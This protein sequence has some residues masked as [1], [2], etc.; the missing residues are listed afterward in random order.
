MF[1]I[2]FD[3]NGGSISGDDL[4]FS[5]DGYFLF[6]TVD[7][8][9]GYD[10]K[11]WSLTPD[12][13][14]L[15][16][17]DDQPVSSDITLYAIWEK[18]KCQLKFLRQD[19]SVYSVSYYI[20]GTILDSDKIIPGATVAGYDFKG[21]YLD[22]EL[23]TKF[24]PNAVI[25][26]NIV[27]YPKYQIQVYGIT[28]KESTGSVKPFVV[29]KRYGEVLDVPSEDMVAWAGHTVQ[30]YYLDKECSQAYNFSSKVTNPF[31][32][33]IKYEIDIM[34]V[35]FLDEDGSQLLESLHVDYGSIISKPNEP[36]R[37]GF[38]FLGWYLDDK[39]YEF[40][41][42]VTKSIALTAKWKEVLCKV[43]FYTRYNVEIVDPDIKGEVV[44]YGQY[45]TK[46]KD[47][48]EQGYDFKCWST[49]S[50]TV[51]EF[52][53]VNTR[54][55]SDIKLYAILQIKKVTVKY[56][57]DDRLKG[58]L[59]LD[60]GQHASPDAVIPTLN[61][62]HFVEWVDDDGNSFDFTNPIL[63]D[64][65]LHAKF[66]NTKVGFIF[67]TVGGNI[68]SPLV[69]DIN[70]PADKPDDPIKKGYTF[71]GWYDDPTFTKEYDFN[72]VVKDTT[73]I[74]ALWEINVYTVTFKCTD[75]KS[76]T[77]SVEYNETVVPITNPIRDGYIF[78][79]WTDENGNEF[80][81]DNTPI[82]QD[83]TV[84]AEWMRQSLS[85]YASSF[86]A[87]I[88]S[89]DYFIG[90]DVMSAIL[91]MRLSFTSKIE[92]RLFSTGKLGIESYVANEKDYR[93]G[94]GE[95]YGRGIT[96]E[97]YF[98]IY[99]W[100]INKTFQ[101]GYSYKF[102]F[103]FD[104]NTMSYV[105]KEV[106]YSIPLTPSQINTIIHRLYDI[107]SPQT[108]CSEIGKYLTNWATKFPIYYSL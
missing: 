107:P 102:T 86:L 9:V 85:S 21:W 105:A 25:T 77:K 72:R 99:N 41:L 88:N 17:E 52:D 39:K 97:Q 7:N 33:Y 44:R 10:F 70:T 71:L 48:Y 67:N 79:K 35:S 56:M 64:R 61:D 91:S 42:P 95:Y 53:F 54:I 28:F 49:D 31:V 73:I 3:G 106:Q 87:M 84:V 90:E 19:N 57:V 76:E 38:K 12:G 50:N 92:F 1:Y 51:K 5:D 104:T 83:T 2:T 47:Y 26:K 40:N 96:S 63:E 27:L 69:L 89:D 82:I 60:Y 81:F 13:E 55:T 58:T 34:E 8:R 37:E 66:D 45:A 32:I 6:P 108:D 103:D 23:K 4:I 24:Y 46:P 20:Y 74:Y 14:T 36:E 101:S 11:G 62:Y 43:K 16:T 78:M 18:L 15:F 22:E 100:A 75:K 98:A 80:D 29:E 93:A 30:G 94:L 59:T 65:V 68:I